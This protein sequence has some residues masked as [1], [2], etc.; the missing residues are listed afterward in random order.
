[1]SNPASINTTIRAPLFVIGYPRSGTSFAGKLL[2]KLTG[3]AGDGESHASTL[4][5]EM[6]YL[7]DLSRRRSDLKGDELITR[8]DYQAF[9]K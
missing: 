1:M 5:Q 7:L 2:T 8:L 6:H 3:Y 9:K 4:L